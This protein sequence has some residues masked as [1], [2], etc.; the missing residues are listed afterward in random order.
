[1][2]NMSEGKRLETLFVCGCGTELTLSNVKVDINYN[3]NAT[4]VPY[5]R[6]IFNSHDC[7]LE[8]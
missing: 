4:W 1:M 7:K 2:K 8:E 5:L 6:Y 3:G